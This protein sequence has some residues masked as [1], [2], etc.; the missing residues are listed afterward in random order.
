VVGALV[1]GSRLEIVKFPI[2]E[3]IMILKTG[4]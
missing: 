3:A 4:R 2:K 1:A